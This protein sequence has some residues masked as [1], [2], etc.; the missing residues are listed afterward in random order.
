[1]TSKHQ[2]GGAWTEQ[3]LAMLK[4]YLEPYAKIFT[5]NPKARYFE[6]YYV[7]AFAG[8][9]SRSEAVKTSN[10]STLFPDLKNPDIAEF[11]K[12]SARIALDINPGFKK[13]LFIEEKTE[14]VRELEKLKSDYPAKADQIIIKQGEANKV[15][16][17]WCKNINWRTTRAVVF[18]DPYGMQVEWPLLEIIAKTHAIDL[19]LLFPLGTGVM[20]VLTRDKP[21]P[22]EWGARLTKLFGNAEWQARFYQ[23]PKEADLFSELSEPSRVADYKQIADYLVE[24]LSTIFAVVQKTPRMLYNSKNCPLYLLVFAAGNKK[25]APTALRIANHLLKE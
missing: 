1:M 16:G 22:A 24:R 12:G 11:R 18:L 14:R 13:F 10:E 20:R 21:P 15:M 25:A 9:G 6:T 3:K 7:D 4:G 23:K 2:F 17:E 8:T 5:Q 19:W